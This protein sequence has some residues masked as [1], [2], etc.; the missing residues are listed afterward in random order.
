MYYFQMEF[1]ARERRDEL[2]REARQRRLGRALKSRGH[3]DGV[4]GQLQMRRLIGLLKR[5]PGCEAGF[6]ED[7]EA[8]SCLAGC[9]K[10][11]GGS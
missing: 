5:E 1:Q 6:E 10:T 9:T 11:T 4:L 7:G 2:L 3:N 8:T